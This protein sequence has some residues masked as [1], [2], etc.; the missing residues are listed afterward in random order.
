MCQFWEMEN[1][2]D[3]DDASCCVRA[4]VSN[5]A[6]NVRCFNRYLRV[7]ENGTAMVSARTAETA[8]ARPKCGKSGLQLFSVVSVSQN[9]FK[10]K[11]MIQIP[12]PVP[13]LCL[14]LAFEDIP[15]SSSSKPRPSSAEHD[16]AVKK[17]AQAV[18]DMIHYSQHG[19][20]PQDFSARVIDSS[21]IPHSD[22]PLTFAA[23]H[24]APFD[25]D[26]HVATGKGIRY[27]FLYDK[28]DK[29]FL[30]IVTSFGKP[31]ETVDGVLAVRVGLTALEILQGQAV[32]PTIF[33]PPDPLHFGVHHALQFLYHNVL[34][35]LLAIPVGY[36]LLF[37]YTLLERCG[38]KSHPNK[39]R[40][41]DVV[42]LLRYHAQPTTDITSYQLYRSSEAPR[43]AFSHFLEQTAL[44]TQR[45]GLNGYFYLVNFSPHAAPAMTR[46]IQDIRR[47]ETR[48]RGVFAPVGPPP[49]ADIWA[50]MNY[51]LAG[52]MV[53]NNYGNH[54]HNFTMKPVAFM[55][56]WLHV[57][58]SLHFAACICIN[59]VF[60]SCFRGLPA[61]F[62][63]L[64]QENLGA[65]TMAEANVTWRKTML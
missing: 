40:V 53:A 25:P 61:S 39:E 42:S 4:D 13:R 35:G 15:S 23:A 26:F 2:I 9:C 55:W 12:I 50:I 34:H 8:W 22:G 62:A 24:N 27:E 30:R 65:A 1:P 31:E 48:Y 54:Q 36:F 7:C 56:D 11:K 21:T 16:A 44:W 52:K 17:A 49:G 10:Y 20:T 3:E 33:P 60:L 5:T 58:N 47:T 18:D 14:S 37:Q 29:L 28:E 38:W 51:S 57:R 63:E 6:S 59:G 43:A 32:H 64:P 41:N 45:L 19:V 46:N